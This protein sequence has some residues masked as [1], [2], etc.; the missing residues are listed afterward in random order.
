MKQKLNE[1]KQNKVT[2]Q[3]NMKQ[4]TKQNMKPNNTK[5]SNTQ[6][7]TWKWNKNKTKGRPVFKYYLP[8]QSLPTEKPHKTSFH[9]QKRVW[10]VASSGRD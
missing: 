9:H 2:K 8:D 7:E 4:N 3:N 6:N 5:Q 1:T 10:V